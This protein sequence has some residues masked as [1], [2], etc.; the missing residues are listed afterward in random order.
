MDEEKKLVNY[1]AESEEVALELK[2]KTITLVI[3]DVASQ[4]ELKIG[5]DPAVTVAEV[6]SQVIRQF[7]VVYLSVIT[8]E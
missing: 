4:K 7:E 5:F 3:R 8:N 6:I 1:A 2:E